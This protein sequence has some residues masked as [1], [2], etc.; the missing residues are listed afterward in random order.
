MKHI[1]SRLLI[2]LALLLF[3]PACAT[4]RPMELNALPAPTAIDPSHRFAD[5]QLELPSISFQERAIPDTTALHYRANVRV[6][7]SEVTCLARNIYFESRA[8]PEKGQVAV[9]Y[10]VLNRMGDPRF[11]DTACAVV[12]EKTRGFCQFSWYCDGKSDIPTNHEA[13]ERARRIALD[14]MH[15]RVENPIGNRIFFHAT[16]VLQ[17][18]SYR[19]EYRI[20]SHRFHGDV[21]IVRL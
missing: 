13:Y 10:V 5:V 11:P 12:K 16:Y 17:H 19:D 4:L 21:Q 9:A 3:L 7:E 1:L 6:T 18:K 15:R 8:E 20:G 14:V 2:A